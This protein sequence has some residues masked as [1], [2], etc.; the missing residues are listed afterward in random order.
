MLQN[1]YLDVK[2]G[3]DTE[4]NEPSKVFN[5]F[6]MLVVSSDLILTERSHPLG[7]VAFVPGCA[8]FS[9]QVLAERGTQVMNFADFQRASAPFAQSCLVFTRARNQYF[10]HDA[11]DIME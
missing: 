2:I 10:K 9:A 5:F 1:A 7:G 8:S 4:E 11:T 6:L 3:F